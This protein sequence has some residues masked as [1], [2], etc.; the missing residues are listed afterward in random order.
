MFIVSCVRGM[1]LNLS[2]CSVA[3]LCPTLCDPMDCSMPVF[4][5]FHCLLEFAQT[6]V[7]WVNDAIQPSHVLSYLLFMTVMMWFFSSV[8]LLSHVRLFATSETAARQASLSITNFRS[9]L[10]FMSIESVMPANHLILC[11]PL[12]LPSIFPSIRAFSNESAL[13]IRW[14]KDWSCSFSISPSNDYSGL[15]S[16]RMDWLD[17]L[18]VQ[19]TLKSLLQ[20]HSS[21]ASILWHSAFFIVQLSHPYMTT[22]KTIGL[23]RWTFLGK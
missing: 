8:Q 22:R 3:R 20:H 18:A 16:F 5:V 2:C 7:H 11:H 15:I 21:K 6:L 1:A 17:L 9:L 14:P 10:K 19:G 4:P 13:C 23:T 12:L